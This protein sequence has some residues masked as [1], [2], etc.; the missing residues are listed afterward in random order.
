MKLAY[1][2]LGF[3]CLL[4]LVTNIFKHGWSIGGFC[5]PL[6]LAIL[7]FSVA[8]DRESTPR[9]LRFYTTLSVFVVLFGFV[10][11]RATLR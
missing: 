2:I 11:Y 10:V 8:T 7:L 4:G 9:K 5:W 6:A 3:G 1:R